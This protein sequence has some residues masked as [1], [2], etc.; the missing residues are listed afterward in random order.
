[1][2]ALL[3]NSVHR[4]IYFTGLIFLSLGILYSCPVMSMSIVLLGLNWLMERDYK[5][6]IGLFL[7]NKTA[8]LLS[9]VFFMH[10]LGL[11][12]TADM[13]YGLDDVRTK[14]PL[15]VLPFIISTTPRLSKKEFDTLLG[16]FIAG[17]LVTT[18]IGICILKGFSPIV[19]RDFRDITP[20]VSHIRLSLM[21]C[22]SVFILGY[23]SAG[24][25]SPL[26]RLCLSIL[27]LWFV[28]FL[29]ILESLTGLSILALVLLVLGI[30]YFRSRK[31]WI[32][33]TVLFFILVI[34]ASAG[35][36]VFS[37]SR[38]FV[39]ARSVHALPMEKFTPSGHLYNNDTTFPIVENG[40]YV[41]FAVCYEELKAGW[42][43]RSAIPFYENDHK[44]N[45]ICQS[46][47]RYMASKGILNKN[48]ET[49]AGLSA[50]DIHNIEDGVTNYK[51]QNMSS[52]NARLYDAIW[53][54][55]V[56]F[57]GSNPSGHSITMRFEFWKTG[58]H[59]L[60][61][62]LIWGIGTGDVKQAFQD[63]YKTDKSKLSDRWQLR[64]HDQYLSIAIAFGLVGLLLFVYSLIYPLIQNKMYRNYF[65]LVFWIILVVSFLTE[66]TLETQAGVTIYALF[67]SLFLFA[68]PADPESAES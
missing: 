63:Q 24:K 53:E 48:A 13:K 20:F 2:V 38:S 37:I 14:I 39:L 52:L 58:W 17:V 67:N 4:T 45:S 66:D 25:I 68:Q 8:L 12:W 46:L 1:M 26:R 28:A 9:A 16:F 51:Y 40:T 21:I 42:E 15:F 50:E 65:Y 29:A 23:F 6:R 55:D 30:S 60:K 36:Y 34:L 57:K 22:L 3:P 10:L 31:P 5:R 41:Y 43:K 19:V 54:I 32:G 64:A 49:I 27:I 44:G 11:I 59:I 33:K 35:W 47:L 56:Y 61:K 18:L 7:N 62:N